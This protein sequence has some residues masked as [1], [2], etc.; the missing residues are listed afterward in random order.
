MKIQIKKLTP[1]IQLPKQGTKGSAGWDIYCPIDVTLT[2]GKPEL[3]PLGFAAKI[4]D[5]YYATII[6]RSSLGMKGVTIAN[7]PGTIDSDYVGEWHCGLVFR[8]TSDSL[9]NRISAWKHHIL[10]GERIGQII[11]KKYETIEWEE[12]ESL[13]ETNRGSGGFG[14]TGK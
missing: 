8:N 6:P 5:G 11:I 2:D 13:P 10:S 9:P 4:P 12:V 7:S 3:I 1:S 14:S